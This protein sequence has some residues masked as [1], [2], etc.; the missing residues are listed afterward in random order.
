MSI[1]STPTA[2]AVALS[3]V[4]PH[5]SAVP[6]EDEAAI[7]VTASRIPQPI[8]ES[9]GD[10]SIITREQIAT[11]GQ[12]TVTDL[13]RTLPGVEISSQGGPGQ[14]ATVFLRGANSNH[15]VVLI[16]GVRQTNLNF[17]LASL[18]SLPL[19]V[20]DRIEVLRAP[21]SSL[22]GADAIGGVIQI[23]TQAG[24]TTPGFRAEVGF[25]EKGQRRITA[26]YTGK[27]GDLAWSIA[28]GEDGSR[29]FDATTTANFAHHPD[30]D[31]N[32][33]NFAQINLDYQLGAD[34]QIGLKWLDTNNRND[35]DVEF[36]PFVTA[37][38]AR[39][40]QNISNLVLKQKSQFTPY[41]TS[42]L[43]F[44]ENHDR[45]RWERTNSFDETV[46]NKARLYSWQNDFSFGAHQFLAAL[47][48]QEQTITSDATA[49][50]AHARTTDSLLAGYRFK[51]GPHQLR[52]NL[53]RDDIRDYGGETSGNL[54]YSYRFAPG[55]TFDAQHG[56][57][58]K[59][60]TFNELYYI[61][62][63][64]F[65]L[66][67]P[68]LRPEHSRT[69]EIGLIRQGAGE[70]MSAYLFRNRITDLIVNF[71]PDGFLGPLPG[72]VINTGQ[73]TIKG[74]TFGYSRNWDG[75]KLRAELTLQDA[76]DDISGDRLP[77]RARHHGSFALDRD[78]G[79]WLAGAELVGQG[80]RYD[81]LP[82]SPQNRLAGYGLVNLHARYKLDDNWSLFA[83]W[84]NVLDRQYELAKG[85]PTPGA[86]LF[87]GVRLSTR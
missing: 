64:G 54:G 85:Y 1:R 19:S 55:W 51:S 31:S 79:N 48:R 60:P 75:W 77:R 56:K 22:Y 68:T 70:R 26:G 33:Q 21:A 7:V 42:T 13:L 41:W 86:N 35:I 66:S 17:G 47:E 5:V 12:S 80:D 73:A 82:N 28:T 45:F 14:P 27:A 4:A 30:K 36:P 3:I 24:D 57:A 18:Q 58:F 61:D 15:T 2:L 78:F 50:G 10:I 71:D 6:V 81:S 25:G 43:Q 8:R 49:Y 39:S 38:S 20:I 72:T 67:N 74:L 40:I 23:F 44:G 63:F 84:N 37:P 59:M 83:R 9:T 87:V 52:L 62:P 34:H 16:D 29:S 11:A 76:R 65:F 46:I 32:K 53:R 69:S